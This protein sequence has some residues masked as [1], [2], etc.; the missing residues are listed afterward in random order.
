MCVTNRQTDR[1]TGACGSV[2]GRWGK[3]DV[4]VGVCPWYP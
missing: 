2:N 4:S 3:M 1:Q